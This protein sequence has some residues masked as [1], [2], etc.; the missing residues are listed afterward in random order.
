M[1]IIS[2]IPIENI[3]KRK[4]VL[5]NSLEFV[6]SQIN[7]R[8]EL[9]VEHFLLHDESD[10]S[11]GVSLAWDIID[12]SDRL[13]KLLGNGAGLKK[14]EDWYVEIISHLES[15]EDAR[16][17]IQHFDRSLNAN[18]A[19]SKPPLGHVSALFPRE[20]NAF[21][22]KVKNAGSF[23]LEKGERF[24]L[25]GFRMPASIEFPV[26]HISIFIGEH[27]VNLSELS[28][29]VMRANKSFTEYIRNTYL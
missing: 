18:L 24:K 17:F 8:Y 25:G 13:R 15:V 19:E 5:F 27:S 12:W 3:D 28:R 9:L 23:Y 10:Q 2:D 11:I 16:H 29:A 21:E 22:V 4:H 14:K 20:N 7:T 1:G 26:D 6:F